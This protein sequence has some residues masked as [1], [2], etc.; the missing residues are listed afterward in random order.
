MRYGTLMVA[1]ILVLGSTASCL[2][3][4][5][6]RCGENEFLNDQAFC[7]A[8][9]P[10]GKAVEDIGHGVRGC[11][12]SG[13]AVRQDD[14]SCACPEGMT[15]NAEN[16]ACV[17]TSSEPDGGLDGGVDASLSSNVISGVAHLASGLSQACYTQGTLIVS[18]F[19][20]C[21][22]STA[23]RPASFSDFIKYDVDFTSDQKTTKFGFVHV[24]DGTYYLSG[25][26]DHNNNSAA[27]DFAYDTQDVL[28]G[29]E[30][31]PVSCPCITVV[32]SGGKSVSGL[33]LD[34]KIEAP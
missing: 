20:V 13:G 34:L 24:G 12:C 1:F 17:V 5:N 2:G 6:D 21:P 32:M 3:K 23:A 10:L 27:P 16:E 8:C 30:G 18:L 4:G 29:Y 28:C 26:F 14:G 19:S 9:G 11:K 31:F 7:V 22:S 25:V 15:P 33:D